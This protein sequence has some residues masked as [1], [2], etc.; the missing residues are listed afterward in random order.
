MREDRCARQ[1]L[2]HVGLET[3]EQRMALPHRPLARHKHMHRDERA[4]PG[5]ARSQR[6]E[7]DT[8]GRIALLD[9]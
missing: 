9:G 7:L 6:M 3:L 5:L 2:A 1:C 4:R 8:L